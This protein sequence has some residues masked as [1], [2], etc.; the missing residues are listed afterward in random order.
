MAVFHAHGTGRTIGRAAGQTERQQHFTV[1]FERR[2]PQIMRMLE[3]RQR[4]TAV[5]LHGELGTQLVKARMRLQCRQ[6][7]FGQRP[8]IE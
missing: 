4:L 8:G 2:Q 7:L 5:Q 3:H 6:S 1:T